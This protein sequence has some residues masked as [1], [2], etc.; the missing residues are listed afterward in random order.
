MNSLLIVSS[1]LNSYLFINKSLKNLL[2]Y[3]NSYN[4]HI[5]QL[6]YNNDYVFVCLNTL[7]LTEDYYEG[8]IS[9]S[10]DINVKNSFNNISLVHVFDN[11]I[12]KDKIVNIPNNHQI[13][14]S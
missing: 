12:N 5:F 2:Y 3:G 1:I 14:Q 6:S 13:C 8:F 7:T 4:H 10:S 11:L 9:I